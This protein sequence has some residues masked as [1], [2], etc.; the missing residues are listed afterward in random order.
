MAELLRFTLLE[1]VQGDICNS[2]GNA[3]FK[4]S[5]DRRF[6]CLHPTKGKTVIMK[7][8]LNIAH[9]SSFIGQVYKNKGI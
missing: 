3:M 7:E 5:I 9:L 6:I 8:G 2:A 1:G 4:N